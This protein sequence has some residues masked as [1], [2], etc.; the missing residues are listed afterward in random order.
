MLC[1]ENIFRQ[2]LQLQSWTLLVNNMVSILRNIPLNRE[3]FPS[4]VFRRQT[5]ELL[6]M[7]LGRNLKPI[8]YR[9]VNYYMIHPWFMHFWWTVWL[10]AT[11]LDYY[12]YYPS[13]LRLG[14][15]ESSNS[16]NWTWS[17]IC[18]IYYFCVFRYFTSY[19]AL[20]GNLLTIFLF[21]YNIMYFV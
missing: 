1:C 8:Y 21:L 20:K 15:L 5:D 4:D 13:I 10:H 2:I 3:T 9:R 19:W 16:G 11:Y 17:N 14:S 6:V 7:V 18:Q 12:Y